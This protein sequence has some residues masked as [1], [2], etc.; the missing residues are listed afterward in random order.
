MV[1]ACDF[2]AAIGE[3]E[4]AIHL[5]TRRGGG[6]PVAGADGRIGQH[7]AGGPIVATDMDD[8]AVHAT[9]QRL[10]AFGRGER[11]GPVRNLHAALGERRRDRNRKRGGDEKDLHD[12]L[13]REMVFYPLLAAGLP[14]ARA[15][16]SRTMRKPHERTVTSRGL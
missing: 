10:A 2:D 11:A 16:P 12:M 13:L 5:R 8:R 14:P 6:L 7:R 9:V 1:A 15:R 3:R 4:G